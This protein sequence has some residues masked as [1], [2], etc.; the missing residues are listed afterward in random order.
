MQKVKWWF[1][2]TYGPESYGIVQRGD[3]AFLRNYN[4]VLKN[5]KGVTFWTGQ[6]RLLALSLNKESGALE[7]LMENTG[8]RKENGES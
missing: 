5:R 7:E 1:D 4:R 2:T 6:A 3:S 8:G